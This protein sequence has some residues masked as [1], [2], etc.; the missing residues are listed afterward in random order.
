[1][2]PTLDEAIAALFTNSSGLQQ[3]G[4]P[5][6]QTKPDLNQIQLQLGQAQKAITALEQLLKSP[7]ESAPSH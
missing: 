4:T 1:M 6:P 5:A 7:A 3:T 2:E